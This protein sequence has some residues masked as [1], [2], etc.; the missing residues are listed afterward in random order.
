[1]SPVGR[2]RPNDWP[3]NQ[4]TADPCTKAHAIHHMHYGAFRHKWCWSWMSHPQH[5]YRF[6]ICSPEN[7]RISIRVR[8]GCIKTCIAKYVWWKYDVQ[9]RRIWHCHS[10]WSLHAC[11]TTGAERPLPRVPTDEHLT[12]AGAGPGDLTLIIMQPHV[13][14]DD[15]AILPR[16][17]GSKA[18]VHRVYFQQQASSGCHDGT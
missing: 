4:W 5:F 1:M 13:T 18:A 17:R 10:W 3:S 2:L 15:D 12:Q 7:T 14:M 11:D 16:R 8:T 9:Y 6:R